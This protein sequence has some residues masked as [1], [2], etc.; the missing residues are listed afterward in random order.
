MGSHTFED[1]IYTDLPMQDAYREAAARDGY[2][3]ISTTGG[4]A[5]SPLANGGGTPTPEDQVLFLSKAINERLDYLEKWG[6]CEA[7]P[8][9]RVIPPL[10][11]WVGTVTAEVRIS[12][13]LLTNGTNHELRTELEAELSKHVRRS[14]RTDQR[15]TLDPDYRSEAPVVAATNPDDYEVDYWVHQ[16]AQEPKVT[17]RA[18]KGKTE[19]RYF[20][21]PAGAREMPAWGT[22]HPSQAEARAAL[23]ATLPSSRGWDQQ[24]RA[25]YEVIS[26]TR[27]VTGDPLVTHT[28]DAT[29]G[30]TAAVKVSGHVRQVITPAKA[31]G[32]TGWLFYGWAAS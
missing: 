29:T 20:V 4:V 7:L 14:V 1:T 16:V 22:G 26:M 5:L 2:G 21:L 8:V 6:H 32:E 27:R 30:K 24:P 12:S 31:T 25:E 3:V 11:E 18:T 13:D 28:L 9:S 10:T 19:T 17:T 23:P 15:I